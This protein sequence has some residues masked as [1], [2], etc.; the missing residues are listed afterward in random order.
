MWVWVRS[1]AFLAVLG[2]TG[3][4]CGSD[5]DRGGADQ[6]LRPNEQE[7]ST[8]ELGTKVD[9][10]DWNID[11]TKVTRDD[12]IVPYEPEPGVEYAGFRVEL[13]GT[14]AGEGDSS[15]AID[16][17]IKYVGTDYRVY[18]DF[19][20]NRGTSDP[21]ASGPNVVAGGTQILE[22]PLAVPLS[23]LGGGVITLESWSGADE[24]PS[25]NAGI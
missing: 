8:L 22:M 1:V 2:L 11:I 19:D 5:N 15:I 3:A 14:Y 12:G 20:A 17:T 6:S 23:A 7:G 18:A 9:F 16:Y 25:W 4:A 10:A 13:T 21:M 24:P